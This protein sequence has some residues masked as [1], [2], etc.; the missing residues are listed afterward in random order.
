MTKTRNKLKIMGLVLALVMMVSLLGM[1]SLTASAVAGLV[2][3][4]DTGESF[5]LKDADGDGY[6]DIGTADALYAFA[7]AVNG[8]NTAINGE[9]T[10]NITVNENVLTADG[11]LNGDG[12]NFRAWTPIGDGSN[13]Y[14]G[15]FNGNGYTISGLYFNNNE[16]SYVGLFGRV[17]RSG[18]VTNVGIIDNYING[19]DYIGGVVGN[20]DYG[21]I[22]NCYNTGS[23]CCNND[24]SAKV[25]GVVGY[26]YYGTLNNCYNTGN[27]SGTDYGV[28][29]VVGYNFYGTVG[30]CYNTGTVSSTYSGVGGVAGVTDY[31]CIVLNSY[32]TGNISGTKYIGGVVGRLLNGSTVQNCYNT[33]NVSGTDVCV[34]GVVGE[35]Y[36]ENTVTNCYYLSGCAKDGN[37]V[38]QFG[39]GNETKGSTTADVAD[40]TNSR[41]NEQFNSGDICTAVGYHAGSGTANGFCDVCDY[42]P[43]TLNADGYYEIGNAGQLFWFAQQV[44]IAGNTTANAKLTADIDLENRTW[45]PIGVYNDAVDASGTTAQMMFKGTLDGCGYTVSNFTAIGTGSI[46]T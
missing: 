46:Q 2:V 44:N 13:R 3:T 42:A 26:N 4:I 21:T 33:G 35:I 23:V 11:K 9:L 27:V 10:A 31:N 18:K 1:F 20:N 29:G 28:G 24:N 34:G 14:T 41:T 5:T 7:A 25:G 40:Q 22:E 16:V 32:N 37:S 45:Y 17:T 12:S 6:Y 8:G 15:I 19:N 43:A 36:K 39:V 30:N 38:T